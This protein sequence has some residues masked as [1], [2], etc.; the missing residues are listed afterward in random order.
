M[1][2]TGTFHYLDPTSI[3]PTPNPEVDALLKK[4]W[5]LINVWRPI[6]HAASDFPLAVIDWRTT[7]PADLAPV[8]LLYPVRQDEDDGGDGGKEVFPD[9][10][11]ARGKEGYKIV[12]ANKLEFYASGISVFD[13]ELGP[14]E[15]NRCAKMLR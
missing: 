6:N 12:P 10:T 7:K 4:R 3:P 11:E 2:T 15:L 9:M 5:Q 8:D 14:Q 13:E 1:S